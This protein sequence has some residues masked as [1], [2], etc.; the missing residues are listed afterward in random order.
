MQKFIYSLLLV[1]FML[2][3]GCKSHKVTDLEPFPPLI[4]KPQRLE[5]KKGF[6]KINE[7]TTVFF[8]EEFFIAGEFLVNYIQNGSA[9]LLKN[10]SEEKATIV[11][12]K[13]ASLPSE[14]YALSVSD[15]DII[16]KAKDASGA[17]YAIQ[18]LRQLMPISLEKQK[19]FQE[20]GFSI[21][22]VYIKDV[23][24]FRYR[25]MHLDVGRL[26]LIHI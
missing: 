14:G 10:T 5:I 8:E 18:T 1:G 4:P 7:S 19:G 15:S 20:K 2:F 6:F 23:P 3:S 11:I 24:T 9:F 21:P 12:K 17:F 16:I 13:D 26:S 25:G 22:Q